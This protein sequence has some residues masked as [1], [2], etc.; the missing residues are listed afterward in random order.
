LSTPRSATGAPELTAQ[1]LITE[2]AAREVRYG[3]VEV[4]DLD[5][6]M[7]AKLVTLDKAL[8]ADGVALCSIAFGLT[9]ADDVYESPASSYANGFPDLWAHG[10]PATVRVLP[11]RPNVASVL[12]D[13][14]SPDGTGFPLAPRGV[15]R[16]VTERC[17][18]LGY[19]PRFAVEFEA[20]ILHAD[21]ELIAAGRHHE[22]QPAGR[23]ANAYSALRLADVGEL[24]QEFMDRMS[25]IKIPVESFHTELGRGMVEFALAH[26]PALEAADRAARAKAY[27][28]ELCAERNLVATFMAKWKPADPGCGAHVHQSLWRHGQNAF[29][30]DRDGLSDLA[31]HYAAGQLA[32]M[33]AFTALFNPNVNSYRRIG[34]AAWTPENATWGIDNRTAAL[35]AIAAPGPKAARLEHRR[36]G[37]DANPY[38]MI[39]AMLAGGLH[40]I[41]TAAEPPE[42]ARGNAAEDLRSPPLPGSL[43]DAIA[44]LRGS[45]LAREL[46]GSEFVDHFALSRQV[47]WDLWA[48][49]SSA[50]VTEW[51]L[52]R[53]FEV[54]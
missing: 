5:G 36:P 38:L 47:E 33:P 23:T 7:R 37:A 26:A 34:V 45:D 53:Y 22:L 21:A 41:E 3:R 54:T 48:Q 17:T 6:S 24:G 39:A 49:W 13:L 20:C 43:P 30:G 25:A 10:D 46:L 18:R 29:A 11:W 28:K 51:E 32:T 15:L 52:R 27:F 19:E 2:L 16:A 44:A 8:G 9:V 35:R 14:R 42:P 1:Q 50:Q 31:R 12:C 40:G 4:P